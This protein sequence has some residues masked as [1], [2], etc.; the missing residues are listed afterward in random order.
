MR[1]NE[2]KPIVEA[3]L[4]FENPNFTNFA[5]SPNARTK[6]GTILDVD[7]SGNVLYVYTTNK[8][9]PIYPVNSVDDT[10][11]GESIPIEEYAS[12]YNLKNALDS[13]LAIRGRVRELD[14]YL[15]KYAKDTDKLMSTVNSYKRQ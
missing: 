7:K 13:I 2:I 10:I 8:E 12:K 15:A 6:L 4:K 14:E 1:L 11:C 9:K 3:L 5:V